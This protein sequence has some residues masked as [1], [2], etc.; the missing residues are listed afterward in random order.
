MSVMFMDTCAMPYSSMY[1]PMA[2]QPLRVPGIQIWLPSG[3]LRS[4]PVREPPSRALRPFSRTSN[5]TAMARRVLVVFR[6]KFTATRKLRAPTLEAPDFWAVRFQLPPKSGLRAS[7]AIFS[8]RASYSPSR[9]TARFF[10]SGL[11]AAAS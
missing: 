8:G 1:Q 2:L 3:S 9:H 5:A 7:S 4:L 11:K 6:L 10:L